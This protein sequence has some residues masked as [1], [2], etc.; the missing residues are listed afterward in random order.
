VSDNPYGGSPQ[1]GNQPGN[2]PGYGGPGYGQPYGQPP[3]YGQQPYGQ[4]G[5]Q[6]PYAPPG[7]GQNPYGPPAYQQ[8]QPP[9]KSWYTRWWIWVIA[10]LVVAGAA[11][12]V[13]ALIQ[14]GFS[15]EKK[16]TAAIQANGDTVTSVS[17]PSDIKASAPNVY[18]CSA[19]VDG[20]STT[21][22]VRFTGD[23]KFEAT[24][25]R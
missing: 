19:T 12:A 2:Q 25:N 13:V 5:Y 6:Q 22:Q 18:T 24:Y 1:P 8:Q 4:P 17:C 23:R 7:Y 14:P 15:L 11:V 21:L 9:P 16:L 10:V 3:V 20:T